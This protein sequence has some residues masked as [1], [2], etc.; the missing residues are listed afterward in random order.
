MA[1]GLP[2]FLGGALGWVY[3]VSRRPAL[4]CL[5]QD[6]RAPSGGPA[7]AEGMLS[8]P[9][10]RERRLGGAKPSAGARRRVKGGRRQLKAGRAVGPPS[11][12]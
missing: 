9:S 2:A 4:R 5:R 11:L 6:P 7:Q 8:H 12:Y 10:L 3:P 1:R